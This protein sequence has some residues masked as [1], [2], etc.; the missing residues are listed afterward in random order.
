MNAQK[1][2]QRIIE[3]YVAGKATAEE[4]RFVENY[5]QYLDKTQEVLNEIDVLERKSM[6]DENLQALLAT[7]HQPLRQTKHLIL[8]YS[9]AAAILVVF[10]F[11]ILLL[12]NS[13][14][15]NEAREIANSSKEIDVLPGKDRA[16][17]TLANG[18]KIILDDSKPGKISVTAQLT[19]IKTTSGQLI[20]QANAI[21]PKTNTI[22]Y[23]TIETP[24]G[25]Q[26]QVR[27]PDGTKVWLNA[28]SSLKYP[29][30][31]TENERK[32]VLK[33]EAYFEVAK[34]VRKSLAMGAESREVAAQNVPFFVQTGNQVVEVLGT[35]FNVNGYMDEQAIKTT[36][37]E[38]SVNVLNLNTKQAKRI[39]PGQQAI[40]GTHSLLVSNVETDDETAWKDGQFRFNNSNLKNILYQLERWYDVKIDYTTVP[41]KRY[42]GMV[43]RKANLSEVL[44]MLELT[45]NIDFKIEE[46]RQL[47]VLPK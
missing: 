15:L 12:N 4:I 10:G 19:I 26:Y 14:S 39:K 33:G 22:A 29:E 45:G 36:L 7:I 27:L 13:K 37:V 42:N 6:E 31:F 35:H 2:L 38:G 17:L 23:N 5:Y 32:V 25:G 41:N 18:K 30:R 43:P 1:D 40:I 16:I 24:R 20:Y 8:R 44:N 3:R 34:V 21:S 47:K 46:G 9:I 28:S 11:G